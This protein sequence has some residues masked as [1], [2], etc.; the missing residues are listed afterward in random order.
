MQNSLN[1]KNT[2]HTTLIRLR[3]TRN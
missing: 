2:H 3:R 1:H